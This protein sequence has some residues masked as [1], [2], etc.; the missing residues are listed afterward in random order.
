[1]VQH[2]RREKHRL[3]NTSERIEEQQ[4][5]Y[6]W[7]DTSFSLKWQLYISKNAA[8]NRLLGSAGFCHLRV[9]RWV[10][11]PN[12]HLTA[13]WQHKGLGLF[14]S[15][16]LITTWLAC[17]STVSTLHLL[18]RHAFLLTFTN[19]IW[20]WA[21]TDHNRSRLVLRIRTQTIWYFAEGSLYYEHSSFPRTHTTHPPPQTRST[22]TLRVMYFTPN[23]S[24]NTDLCSISL[25]SI[26][27]ETSFAATVE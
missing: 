11:E 10:L 20:L 4:K 16:E 7:P 19:W 9:P 14:F 8:A 27:H 3:G 6:L 12:N 1:M 18:H 15:A 21:N 17:L 25:W 5:D 2:L 13:C 24:T 26:R 23:T 22:W